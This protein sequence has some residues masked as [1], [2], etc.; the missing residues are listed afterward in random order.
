MTADKFWSGWLKITMTMVVLMGILL[1][2][3]YNFGAAGFL[4][5]KID[6]VFFDGHSPGEAVENLKIWMVSVTGSVIAAWGLSMLYLV[7]HSLKRREKWAWRSIF[8]PVLVW[9]LL[10]TM[11]SAYHG[12]GFNVII[13]TILF[14]QVIAP[15]LFLRNQF[16][17]KLK[18]T[19]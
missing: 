15:L 8:Y 3:L 9:Y 2:L 16:F 18:S 12:V 14:L 5:I 19:T 6:K 1:V 13:N 17:G 10:D 11:V 7:N 4:H